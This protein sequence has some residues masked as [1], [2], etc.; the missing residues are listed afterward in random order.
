MLVH[1]FE[2]A[3]FGK[4]CPELEKPAIDCL[5]NKYGWSLEKP[6]Y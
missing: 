3:F 5:I 4:Q 6:F 2:V 1:T